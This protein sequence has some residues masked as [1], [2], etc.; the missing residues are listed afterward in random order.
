MPTEIAM[1]LTDDGS[2]VANGGSD[3]LGRTRSYVA[4]RKH[5]RDTGAQGKFAMAPRVGLAR[6][7]AGFA[8]HYKAP[9]VELYAAA[10]QPVS[11]RISAN[12]QEEVA[13]H[14]QLV[15]R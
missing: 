11:L 10:C 6:R 13:R 15:F 14:E 8:R 2:T 5:A 9:F 7:I 3:P 12:E 4:D 1:N